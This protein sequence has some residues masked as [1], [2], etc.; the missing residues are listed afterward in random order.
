MSLNIA[1]GGINAINTQLESISNNIANAGTYGFKSSRAN[2]ASMYADGKPIGVEVG[3]MSQTIGTS[4]GALNTGRSMDAAIQGKGFFVTKDTNGE[5]LFTR[6]GIFGA[7]KDGFVTD[8]F[9]RRVQGYAAIPNS[10]ALGAMG[11][12]QIQKG[13]LPA[14]ASSTLDYVGNLSADWPNPAVVPFDPADS[15]TYNGSMV[16]VVYD[17]QGT[18]HTVTQFF[19]KT[20][21]NEVTVH[22]NFNGAPLGAGTE[23]VLQFGPAGQLVAPAAP[24]V[25]NLPVPATVDPIA[26]AVN[27]NGTT[28]F[29]GQATTTVNESNGYASG[30]FVGVALDKDGSVLAQY[31]NGLK[32]RVGTIALANFA[33]EDGLVPVSDTSWTLSSASGDPLYDAPGVGQAGTISPGSLEQSNVDMTGELVGLMTAQR[34]YQA[35]TK[36]F[37]TQQAMTQALMQAV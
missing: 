7:D 1:L 10:P 30:S 2:F 6:V 15:Q 26:L 22:Y 5:T 27:Y 16:S 18:K 11:D 29:A 24:V 32:Q 31:S 28:Q 8:S 13:Q 37:S 23:T 17:S 20:N 35:N 14:Q 12:I 19:V 34:N 36:V 3:S 25:K 4:G 21:P 9:G 33:N